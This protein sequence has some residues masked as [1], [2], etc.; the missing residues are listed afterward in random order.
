MDTIDLHMQN[1]FKKSNSF[2]SESRGGIY[3]VWSDD[4][5][6]FLNIEDVLSKYKQ[7]VK[8]VQT[9]QQILTELSNKEYNIKAL[10]LDCPFNNIKDCQYKQECI[11]SIK[12]IRKRD[13][14]LPLIS[15]TSGV[16]CLQ[17]LLENDPRLTPVLKGNITDLIDTLG[18]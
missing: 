8:R 13:P 7:S 5:Q 14:T 9:L 17:K 1:F 2:K 18:L 16:E 12:E 3:L 6:S 4:I 11:N 10:I 15:Y